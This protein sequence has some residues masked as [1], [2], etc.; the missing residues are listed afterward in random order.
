MNSIPEYGKIHNTSGN[1]GQLASGNVVA[2]TRENFHIFGKKAPMA[3]QLHRTVV[4]VAH[5][6]PS[7]GDSLHCMWKSTAVEI[8]SLLIGTSDFCHFLVMH[9]IEHNS[10]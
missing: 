3:L 2:T 6:S 8:R 9:L 1:R 10:C 5:N 4:D 7:E